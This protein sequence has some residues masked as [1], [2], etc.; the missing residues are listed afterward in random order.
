MRN[1]LLYNT[2]DSIQTMRYISLH[3]VSGILVNESFNLLIWIRRALPGPIAYV[4][5]LG[6]HWI[7]NLCR[8]SFFNELFLDWIRRSS[9]SGFWL[10]KLLFLFLR[11]ISHFNSTIKAIITSNIMF[12]AL[13][14]IKNE[15]IG[16]CL[17]PALAT[18]Y[19]YFSRTVS[20]FLP[21]HIY[22]FRC[23]AM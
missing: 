8:W 11:R 19:P 16:S 10:F 23:M 4:I 9:G 20:I 21:T 13:T 17:R 5:N 6:R 12:E 3:F 15:I 2:H 18:R 1:I 14:A 7:L 22:S